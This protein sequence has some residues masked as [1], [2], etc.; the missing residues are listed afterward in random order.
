M[1]WCHDPPDFATLD[2]TVLPFGYG[3][4]YGDSCLN[5]GGILLDITEL[6]R[7]I[8]FDAEK[9]IIRCEAG[10]TLAELLDFIVPHGWFLPVTPGTKFISIGGAIAND[11][12][13]K[14]HH[15]DG[16]FGCHVTQFEL[17]RSSGEHLICSPQENSELYRA[18]IGG[19]GLTGII[20]WAEFTLKPILSAYVDM[21]RIRFG[22]LEEFFALA[23]ES[24]EDYIYTVGWLDCLSQGKNFGRGLYTRGNH[25]D[26]PL[27]AVI[28]D[29]QAKPKITL[30][31]DFPNFA[32]NT[33]TV[34]AFNEVYYRSQLSK[35]IRGVVHYD[36]FFYPLDVANDWN[37]LYGKRGFMQYQC[38][39]PYKDSLEPIKEIIRRIG[40]SGQGS[41]LVVFKIFGDV[42]SPGM[43]SFPRP[44][45]TLAL[46]FPNNGQR[47]LTLLEDLDR[48]VRESGG[49]KY[50]A[51]DAHMSFESFEISYPNWQEF[52]QHIDP[53]F[54][55]SFWRRMMAGREQIC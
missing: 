27:D 23:D 36:P 3:R 44:G 1:R 38:V 18:T 4:S 33:L 7:L 6:R 20:T 55:S 47:T 48:I 28:N 12:H 5:N 11:V 8:D 19:L 37:R 15:V 49:A 40:V 25:H 45:V 13:G 32:I 26:P 10:I 2:H 30:P 39:V 52:A 50:P 46:D 34:K 41:P 35:I 31:I 29:I 14:N 9:G 17:L 54:S 24:A 42:E 22:N 43:L 53:M 16:T 51:K 21:E